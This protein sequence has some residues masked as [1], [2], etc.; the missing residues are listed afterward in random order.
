[1]LGLEW[2]GRS[3]RAALRE[4]IEFLLGR[5]R[6]AVITLMF[7]GVYVLAVWVMPGRGADLDELPLRISAT[8]LPLLAFPAVFLLKM[9]DFSGFVACRQTNEYLA[10]GAGISGLVYR[11]DRRPFRRSHP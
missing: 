8:V 6:Q 4:T 7:G 11:S 9:V 3:R 1:M 10:V 5:R 2:A